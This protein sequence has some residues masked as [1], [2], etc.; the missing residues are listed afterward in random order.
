MHISKYLILAAV[1]R[2]T[3]A[4]SNSKVY[5]I[6]ILPN[7]PLKQKLETTLKRFQMLKSRTRTTKNTFELATGSLIIIC[8][9]IGSQRTGLKPGQNR[10][11]N[12]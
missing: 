9:R 1:N 11:I 8:L 10:K 2:Q 5:Y 7:I 6:R 3:I 4:E 12:K